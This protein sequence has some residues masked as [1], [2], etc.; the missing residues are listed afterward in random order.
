ML[1]ICTIIFA[2]TSI[3]FSQQ[4]GILK[5]GSISDGENIVRKAR[6]AAGLS[7]PI[8]SLRF[9]LHRL[10]HI[11]VDQTA[12]ARIKGN[13]IITDYQDEVTVLSSDKIR[14]VSALKD[15]IVE[16]NSSIVTSIWNENK[17]RQISEYEMN[18]ER[19]VRD[20]TAAVS[21]DS[22]NQLA[23][24]TNSKKMDV[25][26]IDKKLV[27]S[28]GLWQVAFP[29]LLTHPIERQTKFEYVGRAQAGEQIANLVQTK[30]VGGHVFQLFFDEKTS[31]LLLMIEKWKESDRDYEAKY[32][33]SNRE[34]RGDILIPTKVK[35]ER[36]VT[37]AGQ[38]PKINF[39]YVDVVGFEINPTIKPDTFKVN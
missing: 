6:D 10:H 17:Y 1:K 33:F 22:L 13:E 9:K 8:T 3:C 12:P 14:W 5:Q 23:N 27:F 18:G 15:N 19:R 26:P 7:L 32:Y 16:G 39:E 35:V 20:T 31:N 11:K 37:P 25:K 4:T 2:L 24:K 36:K 34:K 29:F 38:S 30:S 21:I 28:N